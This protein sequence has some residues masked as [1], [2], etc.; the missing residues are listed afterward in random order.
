MRMLRRGTR[1]RTWVEV[2]VAVCVAAT[3]LL[4]FVPAMSLAIERAW[5]TTCQGHLAELFRATTFYLHPDRGGNWLPAGEPE[6]PTWFEK[7]EPLVAGYDR[8]KTRERFLCPKAPPGQRGFSRDSLSFG[9]NE[10]DL[11]FGTVASQTAQ[12][13]TVLVLGDSLGSAPGRA[14][15]WA[16][17]VVTPNGRFRLDARHDDGAHLL[18]LDG[19][20]E[21]CSRPQAA[22]RWTEWALAPPRPPGETENPVQA[23]AWWQWLLVVGGMVGAYAASTVGVRRLAAWRAARAEALRQQQEEQER[24]ALL[25]DE[26]QRAADRRKRLRAIPSGPLTRVDLPPAELHVGRRH[27]RIRSD[28]EIVIG[29]GDD[30]HVRIVNRRTVSRHHAKIRPDERGYVLYDLCSRSGTFVRGERIERHVLG[31]REVIWLGSEVEVVFELAERCATNE[32]PPCDSP[33]PAPSP[34]ECTAPTAP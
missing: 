30:A 10:A 11:P 17:T 26:A 1:A 22:E 27:Y 6:G 16:D 13:Q 31:K 8:G 15:P 32:P 2:L 7:L 34:S 5:G 14:G 12:P 19:H 21:A 18:F 29:R 3:V 24:Q 4:L 20:V 23:V 25:D 9:W 28:Q 33:S